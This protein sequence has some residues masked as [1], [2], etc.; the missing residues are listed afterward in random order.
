MKCLSVRQP[1]AW[2]IIHAGK[3][4]EN[5]NWPT[6]Y[7]GKLVIHAGKSCSLSEYEYA[8]ADIAK[9]SG[10]RPPPLDELPRG[11]IVGVVD[12]VDCVEDSESEW[13][14]EDSVHWVVRSPVPCQPRPLKGMLG[15]FEVDPR[16]VVPAR[17]K[18]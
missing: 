5:R 3:D 18:K 15:L 10:K 7:R 14:Q 9:T 1:W 12:L 2:A 6:K 4:V 16:L 8:A 11:C 13:A 17:R